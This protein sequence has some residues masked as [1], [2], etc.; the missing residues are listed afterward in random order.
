MNQRT[1]LTT[2]NSCRELRAQGIRILS[3]S[4]DG[5]YQCVYR[6]TAGHRHPPRHLRQSMD[7]GRGTPLSIF[8]W[9]TP[10]NPSLCPWYCPIDVHAM[11][12]DDGDH[13]CL[14]IS[15][16]IRATTKAHLYFSHHP[17]HRS[18]SYKYSGPG[19]YT[20]M[21]RNGERTLNSHEGGLGTVSH[22][23]TD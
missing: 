16:F 5:E 20:M 17:D 9:G 2:C 4:F 12:I 11:P 6:Y 22:K 3:L 10:K 8:A 18:I 1:A 7:G 14:F 15:V 13:E 21:K 23:T 19:I